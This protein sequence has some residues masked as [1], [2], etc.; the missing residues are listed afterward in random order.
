[1]ESLRLSAIEASTADPSN[2]DHRTSRKHPAWLVPWSQVLVGLLVNFM[3]WGPP[4]SYGVF[5][6]YY[7][8]TTSWSSSQIS[9]VGS[10]Q[11]FLSFMVGPISGRLADAGYARHCIFA[12]SCLSVLGL[13]MTSI[14]RQYWQILLSQGICIGLGG[15]MMAMPAAASIGS[16]LRSRRALAM[17]VSGCGAGIGAIVYASMVQYLLPRMGFPWAVRTCGFVSLLCAVIANILSRPPLYTRKGGGLVDWSAFRNGYFS[18]FCIGSFFVY[19]A[20]FAV[21]IYVSTEG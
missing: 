5:Q 8:N 21:V 7:S 13:M 9:W 16:H 10:I 20:L 2:G 12:G 17:S 14:S 19:I 11:L 18:L 1:M 6:L 4:N 15:G 3:S